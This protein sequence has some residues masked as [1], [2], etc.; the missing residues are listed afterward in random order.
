MKEC[1]NSGSN[2][3]TWFQEKLMNRARR[4][5]MRDITAGP[6]CEETDKDDDSYKLDVVDLVKPGENDRVRTASMRYTNPIRPRSWQ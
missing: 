2:G 4:K 1:N 5:T 3:Y 6:S